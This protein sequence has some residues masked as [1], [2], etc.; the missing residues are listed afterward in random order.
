M[1]NDEALPAL[2]P[3][4]ITPFRN[5]QNEVHFA[6]QDRLDISPAPVAVSAAGYF[7]LSCLNGEH[8]RLDIQTAF[9]RRFGQMIRAAQIDEL[10]RVLDE[11]LLLDNERFVRAYAERRDV[12]LAAPARD[13]RAGWPSATAL[14]EQ[15]TG[16][17]ADGIAAP[18]EDLRGIIAPHL[19]NE[20]GA[21]CYADAYATLAAAPPADRYVV[22]GTNHFGRAASAVATRQ[23]FQTPLGLVPTDRDFINLLEQRLGLPLCEYELDH[24]VEHSIELQVHLLQVCASGRPFQI[25]PILCPDPC[26]DLAAGDA[27][28]GL[29]GLGAGLAGLL[30]ETREGTI[31][32]AGADLSHVGQRFGDEEPTTQEFMDGV[33]RHDRHLT[34]LLGDRQERAFLDA[35]RATSNHTRVCSAGCL[36]TTLRALPDQPCRILG[37]HQAANFEA[38]TNV[39]CMAAAIG[40]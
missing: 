5:A 10:V 24:A 18:T 27:Q 30:A 22:L 16:I 8:T 2:R 13:N 40:R 14:R 4:E 28:R 23:D 35:L 31:I 3:L 12:Y 1:A 11:A 36:Y 9:A 29:D 19:D 34:S 26:L 38:E 21:P 7:I 32:I 37:Y 20:R 33:A 17:L 6:L 25:V 15:L 39:T